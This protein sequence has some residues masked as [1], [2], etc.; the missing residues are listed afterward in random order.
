M[1]LSPLFKATDEETEGMG[2]ILGIILGM[3]QGGYGPPY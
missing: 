3:M 1:I 2:V